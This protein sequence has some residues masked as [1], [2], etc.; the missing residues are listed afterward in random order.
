MHRRD[1]H[2]DP[3]PVFFLGYWKNDG[4]TAAKFTGDPADSWCRT[5]DTAVM[6][7]DGYLWY[8][9]RSDDVFKAAGYRIGPSEI[10]NCLVK[11]PAVANAAVVGKP[12]RQS[13]RGPR[14]RIRG[15]GRSRTRVAAPRARHARTLRVPEGDRIHCQ[16]ADDDDRQGAAP[17]PA[18][19]RGRTGKSGRPLSGTLGLPRPRALACRFRSAARLSG[20]SPGR[21]SRRPGWRPCADWRTTCPRR[22]QPFA[23][24]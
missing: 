12:D 5:G 2:G 23:L 4:A 13:L 6:D 14:G 18:A 7:E 19:A 3:D 9:G 15:F 1:V 24:R 20:R 21:G 16:P 8:Q 10:E 22:G 17:G 11:H